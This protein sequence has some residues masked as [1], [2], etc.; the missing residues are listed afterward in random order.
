[1]MAVN[2]Y[3]WWNCAGCVSSCSV[4]RGGHW[5]RK[6]NKWWKCSFMP[7]SREQQTDRHT[8]TQILICTCSCHCGRYFNY[9]VPVI[10]GNTVPIMDCPGECLCL[11]R[12]YCQSLWAQVHVT[13]YAFAGLCISIHPSWTVPHFIELQH[14]S[15][16]ISQESTQ[17]NSQ[18]WNNQHNL[19]INYFHIKWNPVLGLPKDSAN[20]LASA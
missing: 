20:T 17:N 19:I 3:I 9:N 7:A 13:A 8:Q 14:A 15:V 10:Q 11:C 4:T 18:Y 2:P 12:V 5:K 6:Q 1:M 16:I